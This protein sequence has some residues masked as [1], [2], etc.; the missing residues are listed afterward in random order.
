MTVDDDESQLVQL[1]QRSSDLLRWLPSS[2]GRRRSVFGEWR[3][4]D[5][6]NRYNCLRRD[7]Q[8]FAQDPHFVRQVLP[9]AWALQGWHIVV[10]LVVLVGGGVVL[11][12]LDT[13]AVFLYGVFSTLIIFAILLSGGFAS[14]GPW[15]LSSSST[16]V[17]NRAT[18]LHDYLRSM[19]RQHPYLADQIEPGKWKTQVEQLQGETDYLLGRLDTLV[20]ENKHWRE[21]WEGLSEPLPLPFDMDKETVAKLESLEQIRLREAVQAYRVRAWTPAAAVAGM[22]LE[23]RLQRLC[24]ENGLETGGMRD[25]IERLGAANLLGRHHREMA[26]VGEFF[27]NR[28]AHPT[29]EIFDQE[30]TA[31][32]LMLL[33]LLVRD[34]F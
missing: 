14:G 27:R 26:Q 1:Y 3:S 13:L 31:L 25:M 30:K 7:V 19:V 12:R 28:A 34:V 24:Q 33:L 22:L 16:V 10:G 5:A 2:G 17:G 20:A 8:R 29:S 32:V 23:G 9:P 18:V 6:A 21:L 4:R 15:Y 11:S